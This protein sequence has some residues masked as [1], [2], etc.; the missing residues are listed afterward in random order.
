MLFRF[1]ESKINL[2]STVEVLGTDITARVTAILMEETGLQ[3][4]INYWHENHRRCD[5]VFLEEI[6]VVL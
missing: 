3:Y 2:G 4:R 5:W 1:L 6:R